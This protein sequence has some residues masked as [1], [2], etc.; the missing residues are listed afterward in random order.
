MNT[1]VVDMTYLREMTE[2]DNDLLKEM[3]DIFFVQVEEFKEEMN[4]YFSE[5]NYDDLAKVAHKAKSSIAIMG[6]SELA[7]D[8]K[9][10]ELMLKKSE[11]IDQYPKYISKFE[12]QCQLAVEELKEL[13]KEL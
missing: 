4:K 3:F 10:F 1:K 8:L 12:N 13:Y 7:D 6:M 2:G 5:K 11:E 9:K